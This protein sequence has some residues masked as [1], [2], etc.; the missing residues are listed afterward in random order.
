MKRIL[1]NLCFVFATISSLIMISHYIV[2][3]PWAYACPYD[4]TFVTFFY[5]HVFKHGLIL[6]FLSSITLLFM[7]EKGKKRNYSILFIVLTL[8]LFLIAQI[9]TS[10][11]C[12]I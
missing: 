6:S 11:G 1:T 9:F 5:T 3:P 7:T 4:L 10:T 8:S 12:F 2:N